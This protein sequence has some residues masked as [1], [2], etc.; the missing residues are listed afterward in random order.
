MATYFHVIPKELTLLVA[1]KLSVGGQQPSGINAFKNMSMLT[2]KT[3]NK[4]GILFMFRIALPEFIDVVNDELKNHKLDDDDLLSVYHYLNDYVKSISFEPDLNI[5]YGLKSRNEDNILID[6]GFTELI[7]RNI[8]LD[9]IKDYLRLTF[10]NYDTTHIYLICENIIFRWYTKKYFNGLYRRIK[11]FK[12]DSHGASSLFN[13]PNGEGSRFG[14]YWRGLFN[15]IN[16]IHSGFQEFFTENMYNFVRTGNLP[17]D[18][19]Y[20]SEEGPTAYNNYLLYIIFAMAL[21]ENFN[22]DIQDPA[23][24]Y[25]IMESAYFYNYDILEMLKRKISGDV[26]KDIVSVVQSVLNEAAADQ[27][28]SFKVNLRE[29]LDY[30][31]S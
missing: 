20:D 17:K 22:F 8:R 21:H 1:S 12:L 5:K 26:I 7:H 16:N 3:L 23:I 2:Y 29:M 31:Q 19:V 9:N 10:R 25:G 4:D 24:L 27:D 28:H 13:I 14:I 15:S 18:F 11:D 6:S 30:I